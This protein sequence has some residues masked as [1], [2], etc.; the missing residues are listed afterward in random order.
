MFIKHGLF[1]SGLT[2]QSGL[3][4]ILFG[5]RQMYWEGFWFVGIHVA[6]AGQI[7]LP[8]WFGTTIGDCVVDEINA[9][10]AASLAA[11]CMLEQRHEKTVSVWTHV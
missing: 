6:P 3:A 1:G 10:Q 9:L 4:M 11:N 8:H 5:Q 2:G 7:A